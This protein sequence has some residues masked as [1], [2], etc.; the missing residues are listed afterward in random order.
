M[1]YVPD[2]FVGFEDKFI[3]MAFKN[4]KGKNLA[5]WHFVYIIE[6]LINLY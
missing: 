4:N 1:I 3:R 2:N 5:K 6:I